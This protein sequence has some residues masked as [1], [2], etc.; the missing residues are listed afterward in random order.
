MH[1]TGFRRD[2][3]Q[4][5]GSVS[6]AELSRHRRFHRGS[7]LASIRHAQVST[8]GRLRFLPPDLAVSF[9]FTSCLCKPCL[10]LLD[11]PG[12]AVA[13]IISMVGN[14]PR[15]YCLRGKARFEFLCFDG[16]PASSFMGNLNSLARTLARGLVSFFSHCT[17]TNNRTGSL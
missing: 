2:G 17:G 15:G 4:E 11:V 10:R 5:P 9:P 8:A 7:V 16:I 1:P 12:S 3:R 13:Y 6:K 14:I